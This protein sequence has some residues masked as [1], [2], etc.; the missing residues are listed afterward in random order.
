V[1]VILAMTLE[2]LFGLLGGL[3]M[4]IYGV[5]IM[6]RGLQRAAG[7]RLRRLLEILT[8]NPVM[9]VVVG[10]AVT[11][12]IQSS[13][14]TTVMV[15]GFVNAGLMNLSQAA[16]VIM[17]AN[18]GTT[19][20]AQ[21]IAFR[22]TEAALPAIAV[23][24]AVWL[25]GRRRLHRYI[26]EVLLGFGLLFLGMQ[27]MSGAM[28]PL[29]E[30]E[31]FRN[32][33]MAFGRN[34]LV[35]V[36]VG[37][38]MTV[39]VQSSS[40]TIGILQAVASQGLLGINVALPVLFGDNIGTTVTAL[41]SS[42]GTS[43]TARRAAVIH[44]IF[45]VVGTVIFLVL[46]PL[47]LPIVTATSSDAVRQ[48]ANA[49]T[50]FNVTNAAVQLP[51]IYLLTRVA[52]R[53]VP[54]EVVTLEHGPKYIDRRFLENPS[55]ALGQVT[56][57]LLRM[58]DLAR[59]IVSESVEAFFTGDTKHIKSALN[60]EE[61]VNELERE[62][63]GYL[64]TLSRRSLTDEQSR[65]LNLLISVTNDIERVGDHGT[66]VA[67][68]AEYK[69]EHGLPFSEQAM[70]DL[71][72]MY[73][74]V[75]DVYTQALEALR[76]ESRQLSLIIIQEEDLVDRIEKDL[77]RAHIKRLNEGQCFPGSGVV[78]LDIISNFERIGDHASSIAHGLIGDER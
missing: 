4:F 15:V 40:A 42:V 43:V 45:N 17:G 76:T 38:A 19:V 50:I 6:G 78:F 56:R 2:M 3:G 12:L 16:G 20:T 21:L 25:F 60:K 54:G 11:A 69:I 65:K 32:A 62:I 68:L 33:I 67:E 14:A 59:D 77:R 49:H 52:S 46:L 7:D 18:I 9:G 44:L 58:G 74:K 71:R 24:A 39:L 26:G 23:G 36:L 75:H 30:M 31:G 47:V 73:E 61:V 27:T 64:V 35:G 41:L 29:R 55:I 1:V 37:M 8:T 48:I 5:Q 66:N 51:F 13:S 53:L 34:P 22:L 63:T 57:E 28:A 70:S 10:A 72:Y